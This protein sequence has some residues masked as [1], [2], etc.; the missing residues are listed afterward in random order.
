MEADRGTWCCN[1]CTL[2]NSNDS[3]QCLAC[4]ASHASDDL[5]DAHSLLERGYTSGAVARGFPPPAH[6]ESARD[7]WAPSGGGNHPDAEADA[8]L[9]G[10]PA[11]GG[12][13]GL[14]SS[15]SSLISSS[16]SL[17]NMALG[18]ALTGSVAIAGAA[19]GA[20]FGAVAG[21]ATERGAR[22]GAGIGALAGAIVS[23]EVLD[24]LRNAYL[25]RSGAISGGGSG[26]GAGGGQGSRRGA[27]GRG[28]QGTWMY[29][30]YY[31]FGGRGGVLI[32]RR[33]GGAGRSLSGSG[34]LGRLSG[35]RGGGGGELGSSVDDEILAVR[36]QMGFIDE[37]LHEH[38]LS[39]GGAAVT[40]GG[41]A[42]M[43]PQG[44]LIDVDSLT[45]EEMLQR[46]GTGH[47]APPPTNAAVLGE[48]PCWRYR[49]KGGANAESP[50]GP[51]SSSSTAAV[52]AGAAGGAWSGNCEGANGTEANKSKEDKGMAGELGRI[53]GNGRANGGGLISGEVDAY[54]PSAHTAEASSCDDDSRH[55][56]F[57]SHKCIICLHDFEVG[58]WLRSLPA[59]LHT[60]HRS[61]IDTWLGEHQGICPV[62][63]TPVTTATP[64]S[65]AGSATRAA[66][67]AA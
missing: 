4:S 64:A 53:Q 35:S 37:L 25:E 16:G 1:R 30:G 19:A 15:G 2:V 48:I 59:C 6:D 11:S 28:G 36:M 65:P 22:R 18:R 38:R 24:A 49:P 56:E 51:S 3:D 67:L 41:A 26:A 8:E 33:G 66:S 32:H 43:S 57:S 27:S 39:H 45:Y 20:I 13:W 10:E 47:A 7:V 34:G 31:N 44:Q 60:F 62:C 21:R 46:F 17:L 50:A 29:S 52:A 61:C 9:D 42:W 23:M 55:S 12:L 5:G 40:G 14:I 58:E 54:P 63:R